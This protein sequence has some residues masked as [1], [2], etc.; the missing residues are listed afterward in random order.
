MRIFAKR[1]YGFDPVTR[2]VVAFG[3]E[4]NR[5]AL[6][7]A[8]S[9]GDLIVFV[10]TQAEPTAE[11]ERGRLLGIAE[12]ARVAVDAKD[13]IDPTTLLSF[14]VN[15]D[16]S[17]AWP[18][19]LPILR[20]W[21]FKEPRLKLLD[22]LHEQLTFEATVRAVELSEADA[23]AVMALPREEVSMPPH[24]IIERLA[25]L[26]QALTHGRPTT[27][28]VP[29]DWEG[30]VSRR[31]DSEATTYAMRFGRRNIWKVGH[32]QDTAVRLTQLNLHVPHEELGEKWELRLI[33]RWPDSVQA[34]S[35]E[36]RL[37]CTLAAYRTEGER[38][39]CSEAQLQSAWMA[40]IVA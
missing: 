4:G 5:D 15:P 11:G 39:R 6:I 14:D 21:R 16:G 7:T 17:L 37:F 18:K 23:Q 27:G 38:I 36:Q 1:F 25:K 9:P 30:V 12:F 13:L 3:K 20:A 8:S 28:P 29:T 22:V 26:G 31:I 2:P 24:P 40:T 34:Y 10:G 19:G 32:A 35:M 33:Q